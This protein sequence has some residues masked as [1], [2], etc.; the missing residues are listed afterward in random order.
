MRTDRRLHSSISF[1]T[2]ELASIEIEMSE[3]LK[4]LAPNHWRRLFAIERDLTQTCPCLPRLKLNLYYNKRKRE[5][6]AQDIGLPLDAQTR[7]SLVNGIRQVL[8]LGHERG[9]IWV[10]KISKKK[11][12]RVKEPELN[13]R[14]KAP[15]QNEKDD[16]YAKKWDEA[17][18]HKRTWW[19]KM[20]MNLVGCHLSTASEILRLEWKLRNQTSSSLP[21][22]SGG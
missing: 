3:F 1:Y 18:R 13:S 15:L 11:E 6:M 20:L 9:G 16:D 10:E 2:R 17:R 14:Q 22:P 4:R 21:L 7:T 12:K 19:Y 5:K 8:R